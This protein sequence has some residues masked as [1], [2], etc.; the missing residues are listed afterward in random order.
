MPV[1]VD[2]EIAKPGNPNKALAHLFFCAPLPSAK[3]LSLLYT[4]PP[5]ERRSYDSHPDM[6]SSTNAKLRICSFG[7]FALD[8]LTSFE[9]PSPFAARAYRTHRSCEAEGSVGAI[10]QVKAK[11]GLD[12]LS[13]R[14]EGE[15]AALAA[16]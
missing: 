12:S 9:L 8:I 5:S 1:S 13:Q 4:W 10:L 3:F 16:S 11:V 15:R 2:H 6:A 14:A 7:N